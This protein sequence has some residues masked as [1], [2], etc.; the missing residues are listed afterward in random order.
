MLRNTTNQQQSL[1]MALGQPQQKL[2]MMQAAQMPGYQDTSS[3]ANR[4]HSKPNFQEQSKHNKNDSDISD[5]DM[6]DI[7]ENIVNNTGQQQQ[8]QRQ[9]QN[10]QQQQSYGRGVSQGN[11]ENLRVNYG[12][13][14]SQQQRGNTQS[15]N[16]FKNSTNFQNNNQLQFSQQ[17]PEQVSARGQQSQSLLKQPGFLSQ[18]QNKN[19]MSAGGQENR[20]IEMMTKIPSSNLPMGIQNNQQ[21]S[22]YESNGAAAYQLSTVQEESTYQAQTGLPDPE[23]EQDFGKA[24]NKLVKKFYQEQGPNLLIPEEDLYK[25]EQRGLDINQVQR[26][27]EEDARRKEEKIRVMK[28]MQED[29]ELEGCTF[30]PQMA[31]KKKAAQP[32]E[33]RDLNKFLEDQNKYLEMKRQKQEE[34]KEK[35][36]QSE[37]SVMVSQPMV[38]EKSK[39]MLEKKRKQIEEQQ[40]QRQTNSQTRE[41]MGTAGGTQDIRRP[42]HNTAAGNR[43]QGD[44]KRRMASPQPNE[45][46]QPAI[47][48]KSKEMAER[49]RQGQKIEDHLLM[50]GKKTQ[51]KQAR[52]IQEDKNQQKQKVTNN[53]S[54]KYIVAKFNREFDHLVQEMF[55]DMQHNSAS[56]VANDDQEEG[57]TDK[58]PD[59]KKKTINYLRLKELLILLG[60]INETAANTDSNERALLYE[61][62]KLLEGEQKEEIALNDVKLVIMAILRMTTDNKRIGEDNVRK[63]SQQEKEDPHNFGFYN[64]NEQFCLRQED[65]PKIQKM[66]NIFYLNRL[67]H[68]GKLLEYSK[69]QKASVE[70][71]NYKPQLNSNSTHIAE[72]YRKKVAEQIKEDKISTFEWLAAANTKQAWRDQAKQILQDEEL[73]ECTF[74]PQLI[75]HSDKAHLDASKSTLQLAQNQTADSKNQ[76]GAPQKFEQLYALAKHQKVKQD[77]SKQDYEFERNQQECTFQPKMVSKTSNLNDVSAMNAPGVS[78]DKHVQKQ[79]D[80]MNKAREEKERVKINQAT[81]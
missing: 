56:Q 45:T 74:K 21:R 68:L 59:P 6:G 55:S 52:R 31:T 46:F 39:K 57:Q 30:A 19:S 41:E 3:A 63:Q 62:W 24:Y 8:Q 80:R 33:K 71:F 38:N 37:Q 25:V 27:I 17:P 78:N 54:E 53:Q 75:A 23:R 4:M 29:K 65:I 35:Q 50:E 73:K 81:T 64:D 26:R 9:S 22:I 1:S 76:P 20:K 16:K 79:I 11:N 10:Q 47:S 72:N 66:Y 14:N 58:K 12:M 67:Q 77:K 36:L 28:Q 15:P 13:S 44:I 60:M 34:R 70:E 18:N 5:E 7:D 2:N 49:Q 69:Q 42:T 43:I 61:L 32:T 51:E 40:Q 48:K